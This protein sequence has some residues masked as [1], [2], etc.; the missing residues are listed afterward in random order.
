M[1]SGL[2]SIP[3]AII[4]EAIFRFLEVY[5]HHPIVGTLFMTVVLILAALFWIETARDAL[6][7]REP[8]RRAEP[9]QSR[10]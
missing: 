3:S 1:W 8:L 9:S 7:A 6:A 2:V 4:S 5:W 10:R